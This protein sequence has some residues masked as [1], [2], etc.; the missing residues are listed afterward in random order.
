MIYYQNGVPLGD[1]EDG[2]IA[3]CFFN[4]K[5]AKFTTRQ[6]ARAWIKKEAQSQFKLLAVA[7]GEVKK[8]DIWA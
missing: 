2:Y 3:N 6:S 5:S 7:L 1:I 4:G 8:Y